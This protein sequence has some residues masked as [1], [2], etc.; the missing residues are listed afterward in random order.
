[1]PAKYRISEAANYL[2]VSSKT[3]RR[4]GK[5][6]KLVALRSSGN[7]RYYSEEQLS[8]FKSEIRNPIFEFPHLSPIR[9]PLSPTSS[10]PL[11]GLFSLV[12]WFLLHTT[13]YILHTTNRPLLP[14]RQ[15]YRLQLQI[16]YQIIP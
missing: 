1:M 16:F 2:G 6:G 5:S 15:F 10:S 8:Y 13:Y 14:H 3:L 12:Y 4:W 7:Q 9:Y 11:P